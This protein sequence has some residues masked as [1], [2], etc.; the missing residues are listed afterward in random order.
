MVVIE[1]ALLREGAAADLPFDDQRVIALV[2]EVLGGLS[3]WR[4][5]HCAWPIDGSVLAATSANVLS[6]DI[7]HAE[8]P[9][10]AQA[11]AVREF[12]ARG[13]LV[14]WGAIPAEE[15]STIDAEHVAGRLDDWLHRIAGPELSFEL[16]A[17]S[18]MVS[19]SAELGSVNPADAERA[20]A[21][22]KEVSRILRG[23]DS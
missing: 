2:E 18:S 13:G 21:L 8:E 16:L 22:T 20:L 5:L 12:V 14:I 7:T 17:A 11:R 6:S 15:A 10:E 4:G 1:D 19:A 23:K 9:S 3:G